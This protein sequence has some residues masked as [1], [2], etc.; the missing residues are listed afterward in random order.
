MKPDQIDHTLSEEIDIV[1]SP[2]FVSGVMDAVWREASAPP[3][4]P[5]PW[6]RALPG[7]AAG[8]LAL[9]AMIIVLVKNAGVLVKNA[10]RAATAAPI[11]SSPLPALA[12]AVDVVQVYGIGWIL[13]ALLVTLACVTLSMRLTTGSWRTL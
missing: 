7:L 9:V 8:A 11:Q 5:F 2:G 12:H 4:I 13:L 3:P 10:G 6:K 1:P